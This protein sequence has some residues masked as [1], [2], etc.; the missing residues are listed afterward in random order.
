MDAL[1]LA[2]LGCLA[3]ELGDRSQLLNLALATRFRH[4]GAL[5]AG[6]AIAAAANAA[7]SA[8]AG[9]LLATLISPDARLLFLGLALL[10]AGIAMLTPA[11]APDTLS[12]W[13]TGPL[14]TSALGLFILGFGETSQLLVAAIA[15][16]TADPVTAGIGGALGAIAAGAPVI[17]MRGRYFML[18]PL[19]AIRRMGAMLFIL[20]A[21]WL[22]MEALH[23]H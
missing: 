1:L 9:G 22:A 14:L 4:H 21:A 7:F 18:L 16:R 2:L 17:L 10:F 23:P 8:I 3:C 20:V 6:L 13:R 11:K 12:G 15:A 5:L 19:R